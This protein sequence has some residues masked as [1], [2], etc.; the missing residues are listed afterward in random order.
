MLTQRISIGR[1]L[2]LLLLILLILS[3]YNP[4]FLVPAIAFSL[5]HSLNNKSFLPIPFSIFLL[6]LLGLR[7]PY[8]T[9][10]VLALLLFLL[11]FMFVN[12]ER[13]FP[14]R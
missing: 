11:L 3:I 7:E 6:L 14:I 8:Y 1:I 5:F 9:F 13:Y 4:L 10:V 12:R 2:L